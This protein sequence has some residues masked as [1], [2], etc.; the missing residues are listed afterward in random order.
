MPYEA[1]EKKL[2][3]GEATFELKEIDASSK[4]KDYAKRF[5]NVECN[6]EGIEDY[7]QCLYVDYSNTNSWISKK[8]LFKQ[9]GIMSISQQS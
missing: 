2:V 9:K 1:K 7:I 3:N 8:A 6:T 5:W 4:F